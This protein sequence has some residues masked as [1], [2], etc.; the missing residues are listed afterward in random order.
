VKKAIVLADSFQDGMKSTELCEA[1]EASIKEKYPATE[2]FAIPITDGGEGTIDAFMKALGGKKTTVEYDC[3][4]CGEKK[5]AT[6]GS[7]PDGV[8]VIELSAAAG[9]EAM[10]GLRVGQA[11]TYGVGKLMMDAMR[12]GAAR[13]VLGLGGCVANDGGCGAAAAMG[14]VFYKK[15]GTSFIPTGDTLCEIDNID[16]TM[17]LD[18]LGQCEVF[19]MNDSKTMLCGEQ[20]AAAVEGPAKGA[21]P[22]EIAKLDAGLAHLG[23]VICNCLGTDVRDWQGA[24]NAGGFA[25]GAAVFF[26]GL[27]MP[28]VDI[29]LDVVHIDRML[30][31]ADVLFVAEQTLAS[32]VTKTAAQQA[33]YFNVR[34]FSLDVDTA[35]A[36]A[37]EGLTG[38]SVIKGSDAAEITEMVTKVMVD[39]NL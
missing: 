8:A 18:N 27:L 4:E 32:G 11:S 34:C 2:L 31:G 13:I 16:Y 30:K 39:N 5:Q 6:Y 36:E 10:A 3:P 20:G 25:A 28:S 17:L 19:I 1:M 24:G 22:E 37:I 23:E 21:S 7:L 9:K 33:K 15:D 29:V 14:A 35:G 38:A 26:G 12:H